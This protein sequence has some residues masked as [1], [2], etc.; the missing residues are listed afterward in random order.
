MR[1]LLT[2]AL[3][4]IGACVQPSFPPDQPD[5]PDAAP[6]APD[7]MVDLDCEQR[8][9]STA[10][11]HHNPGQE[12][13]TCHNGQQ[14][15]APIYK[16]AGTAFQRDGVT[17]QKGGTI[18]IIDA[19]NQVVKLTTMTNGNFYSSANLTPPYIALTS[20][21]PGENTP[22]IENFVDGDCNSCHSGVDDPGRVQFP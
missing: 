22:M 11:G 18:I 14:P 10:D 16:I 17:P 13:L 2:F 3:V 9:T 7:A 6:P 20:M 19:N 21:C 12:C 1:A 8:V 15:G 4:L 5:E